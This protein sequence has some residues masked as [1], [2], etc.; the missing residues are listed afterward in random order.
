M[1]WKKVLSSAGVM[2]KDGVIEAI[3]QHYEEEIIAEKQH[4]QK[5]DIYRATCAFVELK[6]SDSDIYELLNKHF[7]V[8]EIAEAKAY[9]KRARVHTQIIALREYCEN[10]GMKTSDFRQYAIDHKLEEKLN[11][12]PKFLDMPAEKLKAAIEKN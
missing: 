1:D 8:A 9:I 12:N 3:E 6:Q 7:K 2:L 11:S 4:Q 10:H 5:Q